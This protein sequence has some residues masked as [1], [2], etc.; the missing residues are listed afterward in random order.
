MRVI[1]RVILIAITL[2]LS[3]GIFAC[4]FA[5]SSP[6]PE[7]PSNPPTTQTPSGP[8]DLPS[9]PGSSSQPD[10]SETPSPS[11]PEPPSAPSE[12]VIDPT[13][14]IY[15]YRA[16]PVIKMQFDEG[17]P[18]RKEDGYK[19]GT[20]S[21]ENCLTTEILDGAVAEVKIRGN[22]TA[23]AN[24]KPYRIKFEK[25][26]PM[27]GL[28]EGRKYKS[29]VLL[30]DAYDYSMSRNY[31]IFGLGSIFDRTYCTDRR[32][33]SLY[34]NDE[35][36][37]V[38]LLAEQNQVNEGRIE[39]DEQNV[40]TSANTGFFVEA[41]SRAESDG[42]VRFR[43]T[44]PIAD[45]DPTKEYF[46]KVKYKSKASK[47]ENDLSQLFT[48]KSDLSPDKAVAHQQLSRILAYMQSVYDALFN[49]AD[50]ATVRSLIDIDSAV[51]M[52]IINNIASLRGGKRSDFYYIDFSKPN[53]RLCFG[54]PWD[55][56][57]DCGN[58]N[59]VD[60]P[61]SF[62]ALSIS[63][64]VNY[65]LNQRPWFV[66]LVKQRWKETNAYDRIGRGLLR[67]INPSIPS[68]ICNYYKSEFTKNYQ[69]W[70]IWGTKTVDFMTDEAKKF[71]CHRDAVSYFYNWM[72]KHIDYANSVWGA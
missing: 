15:N 52:F 7:K 45:I 44:T 22:S 2:I 64:Y 21:T 26:Q 34:I 33:V 58:Y 42:C 23:N 50:E 39:V 40:E 28:N 35:Y 48:I 56:D 10:N 66:E 53:P 63:D 61:T 70:N 59:M 51:D 17:I 25:K 60:S 71:T 6:A 19:T 32:Y 12:P 36:M 31:F 16:F 14:T 62:N 11:D 38:F 41:D 69:K 27:L 18:K 65:T 47:T 68:A 20:I 72:D 67:E 57:V 46:I 3:M 54:P 29:W 5:S 13:S 49:Y 37:G 8:T 9:G 43:D 4:N 55:Y 24:K 1:K 30:A